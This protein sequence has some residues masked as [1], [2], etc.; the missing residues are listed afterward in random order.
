MATIIIMA[1]M[2]V[3]AGIKGAYMGGLSRKKRKS[4]KPHPVE[5]ARSF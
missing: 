2:V 3:M 4:L 5:A 1:I